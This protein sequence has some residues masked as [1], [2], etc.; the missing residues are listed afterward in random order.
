MLLDSTPDAHITGTLLLDAGTVYVKQQYA[1]DK[2]VRAPK[3]RKSKR[4]L[5]IS[6]T[7]VEYLRDWKDLQAENLRSCGLKQVKG[8]PL[9][10]SLSPIPKKEEKKNPNAP[11]VVVNFMDPNNYN[12][13]FR[14]F[15]VSNGFGEFAEVK[16]YRDSR[17]IKRYKRTGYRDLT[18]HML[19]HTQATLLI[20]ANT[21]IKTVQTRLGHS[22]I[23][24]TLN[25][26]S[27]AIEANDHAAS[28]AFS[29][30]LGRNREDG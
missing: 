25:T 29:S 10:H 6:P 19:H 28:D 4:R 20:G 17:G 3:S 27:H 26:Y 18:P 9:V 5:S 7:L 1:T 2:N 16:E 13:W 24:M 8:S 11:R 30:I 23:N 21:D 15:C 22:S 12:R 14:N